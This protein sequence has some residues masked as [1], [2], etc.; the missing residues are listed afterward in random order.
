MTSKFWVI[1][2]EIPN[3]LIKHVK[4]ASFYVKNPHIS[5]CI[6]W[7]RTV[8]ESNLW[9]SIPWWWIGQLAIMLSVVEETIMVNDPDYKEKVLNILFDVVWWEEN[10]SFHTDEENKDKTNWIGCGHLKLLLQSD[11]RKMYWLSDE[12]AAF[13]VKALHLH[14]DKPLVN[15]LKWWHKE[16]GIIKVYSTHHS[17]HAN[18]NSLQYFIYTPNL[19]LIR[20]T[21]IANK[22]YKEF[23]L[24][25][26]ISITVESITQ[27][28]QRK[29]DL[30]FYHTIHTLAP[31]LPVYRIKHSLS[32]NIKLF[33]KIADKSIEIWI[34]AIPE[35]TLS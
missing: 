13:I 3:D 23:I 20:N 26:S 30:N 16:K 34:N 32:W 31:N 6:D 33:N 10:L 24:W 11:V 17:V 2:S 1:D 14:Q 18:Y 8:N 28:L 7:R 15:I 4:D 19:A 27:M 12:S 35:F 21:E 22:I 25:T 5:Q 9:S 29:T